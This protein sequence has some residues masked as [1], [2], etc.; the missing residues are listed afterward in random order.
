MESQ[1]CSVN[2]RGLATPT[3]VFFSRPLTKLLLKPA[4]TAL[5]NHF[6]KWHFL[7]KRGHRLNTQVK[8]LGIGFNNCCL[9][10]VLLSWG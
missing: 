10:R 2:F 5:V 6:V 1:T 8:P 7:R 3:E 4:E 9:S